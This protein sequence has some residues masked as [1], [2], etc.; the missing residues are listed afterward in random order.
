MT[1][2]QEK[3]IELEHSL[4]AALAVG[5]NAM[6]QQVRN[7][8]A[9]SQSVPAPSS[10]APN[11]DELLTPAEAR[12]ML[13]AQAAESFTEAQVNKLLKEVRALP[14][15]AA[16]LDI[17]LR[18][19]S[20]LPFHR[21]QP[22]VG[23]VWTDARSLNDPVSR[24]RLLFQLAGLLHALQDEHAAP[25]SLLP[26]VT[27]A[28]AIN[29]PEARIRSLT[30]IVQQL[31]HAMRV[32]M[33][34]RLFDEIDRLP[35]DRLRGG[36]VIALAEFL[37]A[38]AEAR[39]LRSAESIQTPADRARTLMALA[40]HVP[41][42]LQP[43]LR[44]DALDTILTI[45]NE[46]E[47]AEALIAFAPHLDDAPSKEQFPVVW[48]QTLAIV[49]RINRRPLRARALVA[50]APHL[51]P[52]LLGEAL[53]AVNGLPN[54]HDRAVLLAELAPSLPTDRV[55]ACLEIA[56]AIHG[57]DARI[58]ALTALAR[59]APD[60]LREQ[61]ACDVM[62]QVSGLSNAYERVTALVA[63]TDILP[64]DLHEQAYTMA[65]ESA[66]QI[67]NE[68]ARARAMSL[69]GPRLPPALLPRALDA[70]Y[71]LTVPHLRMSAL[72]GLAPG[73]EN[74]VRHDTL[75]RLLENAQ[76]I[77]LEYKRARAL[78][79][80]APLLPPDLLYEVQAAADELDEA[81]DRVIVYIAVAQNLPP[82]QRPPV[83]SRAWTLIKQIEG[84]YDSASAIAAIAPFLP[85][86]LHPELIQ[87]AS[88]VITSIRDEYDRASAIGILVPLLLTEDPHEAV[89]TLPDSYLA[90]EE[91]L[92]AALDVPHQGVRAQLLSESA[93]V[94][95]EVSYFEQSY[96]LWCRVALRLAEL[97]LADSLLCLSVLL[98]V[99]R[100]LVGDEG[101][102]DIARALVAR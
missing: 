59:Y 4:Q 66:L 55:V 43:R 44:A 75:S 70:V 18:L 100:A 80:I 99:L 41:P 85:N 28:Q 71:Q 37:P 95:T 2:L 23:E 46:D 5:P 90:L 84:G 12:L 50:L 53:S 60:N 94:W 58:V 3:R 30:A 25:A 40:P 87:T 32:R 89:P 65:L 27:A 21:A 78:V 36:A 81:F 77:Q 15:S 38:E 48:E 34:H 56:R 22:I 83:I 11:V 1:G 33:L 102:A 54:E 72:F 57:A 62:S 24:A 35:N 8:L 96:R 42:A 79:S 17:L 10:P 29:N 68:N 51:T 88:S 63:L 47:R 101:I 9:L 16:R 45:A 6:G 7:I 13:L 86:A 64:H 76:G 69:L 52:N 74:E 91:G 26:V 73:L 39:A 20:Y 61:I 14:P 67:E 98:P 92:L 97:P 31:P 82:D 19:A 49:N 93:A